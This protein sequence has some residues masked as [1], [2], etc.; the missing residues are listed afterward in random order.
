MNEIE[1]IGTP[2]NAE[3][4]ENFDYYTDYS[5][6]P[7]SNT[8]SSLYT[9]NDSV[10]SNDANNNVN[11]I[12]GINNN[13]SGSN[14]NTNNNH[15]SS[16]NSNNITGKGNMVYSF[17]CGLWYSR[18]STSFF[19]SDFPHSDSTNLNEH[20]ADWLATSQPNFCDEQCNINGFNESNVQVNNESTTN[21]DLP[22]TNVPAKLPIKQKTH[23]R[24]FKTKKVRSASYSF[25][26]C[27]CLTYLNE[28]IWQKC[29]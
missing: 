8:C 24:I 5:A 12:S 27:L 6:T 18:D 3:H 15:S 21:S 17:E 13:S 11:N 16:L 10:N 23:K 9:Q 26:F 14:A 20:T 28:F 29:R 22:D 7:D 25:R 4:F 19:V 1:R 2:Y